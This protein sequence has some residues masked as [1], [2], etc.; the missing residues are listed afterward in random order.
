[1]IF[2]SY[3]FPAE[4]LHLK[5]ESNLFSINFNSFCIYHFKVVHTILLILVR[6]LVFLVGYPN[7]VEFLH[8]ENFTADNFLTLIMYNII[9]LDTYSFGLLLLG[10]LI[11]CISIRRKKISKIK[12]IILRNHMAYISLFNIHFSDH[13]LF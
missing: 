9:I 1:M 2:S 7:M 11:V 13:T 10:N 6:V 3:Q 4:L 12:P 8:E 5:T